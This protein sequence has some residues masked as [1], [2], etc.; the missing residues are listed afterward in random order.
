MQKG[1]VPA[2]RGCEMNIFGGSDPQT[3]KLVMKLPI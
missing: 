1:G 2:D 3:Y